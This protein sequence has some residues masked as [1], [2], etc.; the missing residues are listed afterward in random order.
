MM[1]LAKMI[2]LLLTGLVILSGCSTISTLLKGGSGHAAD[3][4]APASDAAAEQDAAAAPVIQFTFYDS[5]A[6]W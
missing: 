4:P 3:S 2:A 5:F 6:K 1:R